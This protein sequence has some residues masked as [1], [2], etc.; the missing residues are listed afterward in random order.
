MADNQLIVIKKDKVTQLNYFTKQL[1][2]FKRDFDRN[3]HML[4][5]V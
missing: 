5:I 4:P 3:L 2:K 1:D